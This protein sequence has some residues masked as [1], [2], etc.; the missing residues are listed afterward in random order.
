[1]G[2]IQPQ[3]TVYINN[4]YRPSGLSLAT[5]SAINDSGLNLIHEFRHD[6]GILTAS[7]VTRVLD[8]T[9]YVPELDF[10]PFQDTTEDLTLGS[11][12][13]G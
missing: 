13:R 8:A 5:H 7:R 2:W 9:G 12:K 3:K 6:L 10:N 11:A 1:V 4:L